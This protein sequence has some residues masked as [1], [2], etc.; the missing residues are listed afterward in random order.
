MVTFRIKNQPARPD[1]ELKSKLL[2][3]DS[4]I[5]YW[6]WKM[7][8]EEMTET[9]V[10]R[11]DIKAIAEASVENQLEHQP[12]LKF[13]KNNF[14]DGESYI[15]ALDLYERYKKWCD[16]EGR[17]PCSNAKFGKEVK[18]VKGLVFFKPSNTARTYTIEPTKDFDWAVHFGI[19]QNVGLVF[20]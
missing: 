13:L 9:L 4:G 20:V 12:I 1:T 11:G 16:E 15:R 3:E 5:F 6:C 2:K 7:S 10:R 8:K 19:K 17:K 14:Q 18:K